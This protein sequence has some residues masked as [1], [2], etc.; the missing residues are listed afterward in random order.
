MTSYSED[1]FLAPSARL[2]HWWV[3]RDTP[4]R[5]DGSLSHIPA[6]SSAGVLAMR[7]EGHWQLL[8][9]DIRPS[10]GL[11]PEDSFA[12]GVERRD[13]IWGETRDASVSLFDAWCLKPASRLNRES[14]SVWTGNWWAE[15]WGA[16]IEPDDLASR[17]EIEFD[18]A[19]EWSERGIGLIRDINLAEVWNPDTRTVVVPDTLVR[20]ADVDGDQVCLRRE[21]VIDASAET[22]SVRVRTFFAIE[23]LVPFASIQERWVRPLFQLLSLCSA[24]NARVTRIRAR[25][26]E[27]ER[28]LTLHYPDPL[29]IKS[30]GDR[31]GT[32]S[33]HTPFI[34]LGSLRDC[35]VDFGG[36]LSNY[37]DWYRHGYA[38][39]LTLLIDSQ[40]PL[41][42]HSVG[43]RLLSAARSIETYKKTAQGSDANVNLGAAL[44]DL[45]ARSGP[46]GQ[47]I[48]RLWDLRGEKPFHNSIPY[49][50]QKHAAHGP[51]GNDW[52]FE[53]VAELQDLERHAGALQWLLRW[54]FL[55][56]LGVSPHD[57]TELVTSCRGYKGM[58]ASTERQF[59]ASLEPERKHG[60]SGQGAD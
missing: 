12:I 2:G 52:R 37:F 56:G 43:S 26:A 29:G 42:D 27:H 21:C 53:S 4:T 31:S 23:E 19:A 35:G 40:E 50:R 5:S 14:E 15:S 36:L 18:T 32:A 49:L 54:Q 60:R 3:P 1:D 30:D 39:A 58:L 11:V 45:L 10:G 55:Q 25:T 41:L 44:K 47:D 8:I 13:S 20:Q 22:L 17:I 59:T 9:R 6:S 7:D 51:L 34:N 38:A 46:I 48:I 57:A 24:A 16:W 28:W 33:A